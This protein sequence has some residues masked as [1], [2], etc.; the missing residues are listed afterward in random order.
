MNYRH[1]YHAGNFA[2][3]LKH[4]VLTLVI[5]YLKLKPT[6]FRVIDTHAGPG[7]YDLQSAEAEATGEWLTGIARLI[8]PGAIPFDGDTARILAP[9]LDVILAVNGNLAENGNDLAATPL[10]Y[11]PGSPWLARQLIRPGD[12]LI[13]NELHEQ[14]NAKLTALFSRDRQVSVMAIDGWTALK[15][16]LPPPERRAV[17]L[18]DPPFEQPGDLDRL[19][20][21]LQAATKRFATG[22]YLLWYPIKARKPVAKMHRDLAQC[23]TSNLL[24]VELTVHPE[25]IEDRLNGCGLI[26]LNPPYMLEQQLAT[27]LPDL[28]ARLA[29][30]ETSSFRLDWLAQ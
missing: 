25:H 18:I 5:D 24:R 30:G 8:G 12:K 19:V 6:A 9:Y 21:G 3:V 1:A 15:S 4:L 22:V 20:T 27:V 26:I 16:L 28:S 10:R 29:L 14:D 11:Y 17:I 13:V 2:D 7:R 23:F